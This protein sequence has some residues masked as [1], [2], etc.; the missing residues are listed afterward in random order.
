MQMAPTLC[1][2]RARH[3]CEDSVVPACY[4]GAME[5]WWHTGGSGLEASASLC[6]C[7]RP[8]RRNPFV[9]AVVH[10]A[11]TQSAAV[12]TLVERLAWQRHKLEYLVSAI[13]DSV[14]AE[15]AAGLSPEERSEAVADILDGCL[16]SKD[17]EAARTLVE[18]RC[19]R[20]IESCK[21]EPEIGP[22]SCDAPVP[23]L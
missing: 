22:S 3:C 6:S 18:D 17:G 9:N 2:T 13:V 8:H 10:R 1:A 4:E 21:A 7:D 16:L 11:R 12:L 5:A 19:R 14:A 20:L 23:H 15:F